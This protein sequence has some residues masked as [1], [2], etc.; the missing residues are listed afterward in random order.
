MT[1]FG[2]YRLLRKLGSGGMA[3]AYLAEQEGH[4]G[5]ARTVVVK[6][7]LPHLADRPE[8]T[9]ML[10][11]EARVAARLQHDN[12]AQ[13]YDLGHVGDTYFITMEYV[14]GVD[15]GV[16]G[17]LADAQHRAPLPLGPVVRVILDVCAG[18]HHAH[19][20]RDTL[21][22]PLGLV[23]RDVS[24]PN[25][26]VTPEGTA[27]IIDFG[28]AKATEEVGE[29]VTGA[30]KGKHAYMS[31]EQVRGRPV[32]ARSDQFAVGILLWELVASQRLFR[33]DADF[34]TVSAVVEDEAP[35]LSQVRPGLPERLD[36]IAARALEKDPDDRYPSCEELADDLEN[37]ARRSGWDITSRSLGKLVRELTK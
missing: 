28:I 18:L 3:E 10:V 2:K 7:V 5:F 36:H 16:L 24:P 34:L 8:F 30:L 14:A 27:K 9:R 13:I 25:I 1:G 11:H 12:I 23:H 35:V 26:M 15:V 19:R 22:R 29:T 21:G 32:D 33:R 37:L 6:R 4:A 20:A 17:E 31:P